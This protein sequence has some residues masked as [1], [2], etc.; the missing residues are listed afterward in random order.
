MGCCHITLRF[1]WNFQKWRGGGVFLKWGGGGGV[2]PSMNYDILCKYELVVYS[3]KC[4]L[5]LS[6]HST[7]D[8]DSCIADR[9]AGTFNR[10]E[11]A[12]GVELNTSKT[13]N[14]VFGTVAFFTNSNPMEIEV[15]YLVLLSHFSMIDNSK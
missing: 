8:L 12:Q 9:P 6:S 13:F 2:N 15:G 4:G 7:E 14:T 5:V 1:F 10:Y 3:E 11:A